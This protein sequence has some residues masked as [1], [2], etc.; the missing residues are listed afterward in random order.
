MLNISGFGLSARVVASNTFPNGFTITEFAD[1]ADPLDSPDL[2]AADT[3]M[4]LNGDLVIWT[5]PQGIEL[6]TSLIPTSQGD[7]NLDILMDANRVSKGKR[8]ARDVVSIVW[9]YPNGLVVTA[10]PG[11]IVVGPV[12][13]SVASAG[14]LKTRTY[15][16]RFEQVSKSGR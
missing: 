4:G 11:M 16:F 13:P 15:H 9:T 7:T 10:N 5:R 8:S 3:A 2:T 12:M 1:D 6:S 14:R